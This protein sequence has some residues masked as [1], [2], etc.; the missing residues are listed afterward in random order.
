[1]QT[2][3]KT[4]SAHKLNCTNRNFTKRFQ[5]AKNKPGPKTKK[6]SKHKNFCISTKKQAPTEIE[7]LKFVVSSMDINTAK[8]TQ[9]NFP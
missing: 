3:T 4:E 6:I 9:N 5:N 8:S 1:M 2:K 7:F